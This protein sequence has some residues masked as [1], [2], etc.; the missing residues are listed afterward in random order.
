SGIILCISSNEL[1]LAEPVQLVEQCKSHAQLLERFGQALGYSIEA[2]ILFTKLD[3]L[4]GFCEF[5][6]SDHASELAKP[7]G[8]S[9]DH[10]KQR[11]KLLINYRQQFDQMLEV[12]SQQIINKL[13]PARSSAKRT[14]IREFPL[15]FASLRVPVQSLLQNL[16]IQLLHI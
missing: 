12:L 16:P 15:Q 1:L 13:H 2:S 4:A 9:L 11:S 8:F 7:L 14:L 6:Q 10:I 3:A 5:F